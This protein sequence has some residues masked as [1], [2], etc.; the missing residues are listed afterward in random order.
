MGRV[1]GTPIDADD[2]EV[3]DHPMWRD[4]SARHEPDELFFGTAAR[5][6][7][8]TY[9]SG[10]YQENPGALG[11]APSAVR[12]RS[13]GVRPPPRDSAFPTTGTRQVTARLDAHAALCVSAPPRLCV[14]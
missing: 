6:A 4:D 13:A 5:N 7:T 2:A 12:S 1:V 3:T 10:R 8:R 9:P 14:E 11:V